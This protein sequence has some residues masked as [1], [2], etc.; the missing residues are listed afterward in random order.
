METSLSSHCTEDIQSIFFISTNKISN[1]VIRQDLPKSFTWKKRSRIQFQ[2]I[3]KMRSRHLFTNWRKLLTLGI[4]FY[5]LHSRSPGSCYFHGMDS[6]DVDHLFIDRAVVKS[7]CMV[8]ITKITKWVINTS[9]SFMKLTTSGTSHRNFIRQPTIPKS[10]I[11]IT[12]GDLQNP[13][14][15]RVNR[16]QQRLWENGL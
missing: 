4:K 1:T 16:N 7:N 3:L 15:N 8:F 5:K 11:V 6:R 2:E 13:R 12:S 14:R 9:I 10:L